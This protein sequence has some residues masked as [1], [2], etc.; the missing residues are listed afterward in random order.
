M[1]TPAV[2]DYYAIIGRD[3][4]PVVLMLETDRGWGLPHFETGTQHYWQVVDHV[5]EA[6]TKQLGL[7]LTTLR[8]LTTRTD[9]IRNR[10]ERIYDMES[11]DASWEPPTGAD[12]IDSEQ[13][14]TLPLSNPAHSYF[15]EN[16]LTEAETGRYPA[17]PPPWTRRGWYETAIHWIGNELERRGLSIDGAPTQ[18]RAWERSYLLRVPTR[19]S[20]YYFKALP[21]MF[22]H[23]PVMTAA[24]SAR[25]PGNFPEVI[26]GDA[27]R[28]WM[29]MSDFGGTTLNEIP[30][31]AT[32]EDAFRT[33]AR[34]QIDLSG[35][36]EGLLRLGVPDRPLYWLADQLYLMLD[37][38]PALASPHKGLSNFEIDQLQALTPRLTEM[39]DQLGSYKVPVSLEHGD[40]WAENI[41]VTPSGFL[42]ADW[43]DS[44]LAHPFFSTLLIYSEETQDLPNVPAAHDRIRNAYL[45]PWQAYEPMD[46][47]ID[48][49]NIA[50]VL[51]GLHSAAGYYSYI[52]PNMAD[53]W[54]M[55]NMLP[56]YLRLVLRNAS[57]LA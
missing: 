24:L 14:L 23:E 47:L 57:Y 37:D 42:Y 20:D 28:H 50:Q 8:C 35:D 55:E 33:F 5:N 10:V 44:S 46:R 45:E 29:L 6:F 41:A 49:F 21:T 39:C 1:S 31:I 40:L 12:W 56:Y 36:F 51:G 2:Y 16:W 30:D 43:S 4:D 19:R 32:W 13:L 15:L 22:A 38:A 52:L 34:L 9:P 11:H 27:G 3:R 54:E 25:Y 17:A 53:R 26:G 48:A 7:P 18:L